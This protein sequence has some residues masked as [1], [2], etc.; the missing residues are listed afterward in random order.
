ML[1]SIV[2]TAKNL[3]RKILPQPGYEPWNF[4]Q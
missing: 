2:K 4:S 1:M 3:L